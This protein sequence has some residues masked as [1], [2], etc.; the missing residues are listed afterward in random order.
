M[1]D[2]PHNHK[3]GVLPVFENSERDDDF[4]PARYRDVN[5]KVRHRLEVQDLD[6][7]CQR[8]GTPG[9]SRAQS[10]HRQWMPMPKSSRRGLGQSALIANS[11]ENIDTDLEIDDE[12]EEVRNTRCQS[13]FGRNT[14][15]QSLPVATLVA[16]SVENLVKVSNTMTKL[17]AKL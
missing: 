17:V 5:D 11:V 13:A 15:C 14:R 2:V 3:V 16:N 1:T 8:R 6:N 9:R 10:L 12:P 4:Q 7:R